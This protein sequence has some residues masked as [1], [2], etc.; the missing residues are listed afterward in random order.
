V[1]WRRSA[2][3]TAATLEENGQ[4]PTRRLVYQIQVVAA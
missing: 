1:N 3:G 2:A 4:P